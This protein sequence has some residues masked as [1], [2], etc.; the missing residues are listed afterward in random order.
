MAIRENIVSDG[1]LMKNRPS[2]VF[3][4]YAAVCRFLPIVS[5]PSTLLKCFQSLF[6]FSGLPV[7]DLRCSGLEVTHLFLKSSF[8]KLLVTSV[9]NNAPRKWDTLH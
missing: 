4:L 7:Y 3:Y 9:S 1:N 5:K 6:N 2:Q 8:Y